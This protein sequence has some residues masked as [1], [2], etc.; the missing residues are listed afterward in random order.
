M[1]KILP[2]KK[3]TSESKE[4]LNVYPQQKHSEWEDCSFG[5]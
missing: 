2:E 3:N 1:H 4:S 5:Y